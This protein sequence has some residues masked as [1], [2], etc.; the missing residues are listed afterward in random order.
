MDKQ[1]DSIACRQRWRI[2]DN[3]WGFNMIVWMKSNALTWSSYASHFLWHCHNLHY[4]CGNNIIHRRW[5]CPLMWV[6]WPHW[7]TLAYS[8]I[9]DCLCLCSHMKFLL[10]MVWSRHQHHPPNWEDSPSH[11]NRSFPS[12]LAKI[13][14]YGWI[15]VARTSRCIEF[16]CSSGCQLQRCTWMDTL[17]FGCRCT[18]N[19]M[20]YWDRMRFVRLWRKSFGR[21]SMMHRWTSY[22]SSN[23]QTQ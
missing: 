13:L 11:G 21:M 7:I 8:Q 19:I 22:Y 10:H 6:M 23:K 1:R 20:Y 16:Q 18:C 2:W 12:F 14:A 4:H 5:S 3:K 9:M 17:R 15:G